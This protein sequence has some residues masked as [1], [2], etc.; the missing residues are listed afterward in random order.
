MRICLATDTFLPEIN[1]VTTV[2]AKQREIL[3]ERG[4]DVLVLAPRYHLDGNEDPLVVRLASIPCP[5]YGQVHL[6]WPWGR[7]LA[8]II[9]NFDPDLVH[10]VTEGP[11]GYYGRRHARR[12]KLPLVTSFHTDFPRYARK[13]LGEW[14][15]KPTKRWLRHFHSAAHITMTPSH[16]TR[17]E[18]SELGVPFPV[19]WGRGVDTTWFHPGRRSVRRREARGGNDRVHVLHVGRLAAEKDVET[20]IIAFR[21]AQQQLGETAR[22]CV[23]GDGPK[24]HLVRE[25]LP[26]ARHHGFLDRGDLADLYADADLFVFP[27]PTETCGLV[28]LEAMASRLPVI[29]ARAGGVPEN[30]LDGYTGILNSPGDADQ[31]VTGIVRLVKDGAQRG[32]MGEAARAFACCRDWACEIDSLEELYG[33][34]SRTSNAVIPPISWPTT[35]SVG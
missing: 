22:F 15:V 4:Y 5:G 18:L 33:S 24:G 8:D 27:S 7:G 17:L 11:L 19:L 10:A 32:T 20:L 16:R 1:G 26:F 3:L 28:V 35:T 34:I 25:A 29:A 9:D 2:L 13:Y 6:S 12:R 31:F 30:V 21:S 23:A 14:A